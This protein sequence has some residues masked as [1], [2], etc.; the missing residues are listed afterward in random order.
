MVREEI[1]VTVPAGTF[2]QIYRSTVI[3]WYQQR[4]LPSGRQMLENVCQH[5][6]ACLSWNNIHHINGKYHIRF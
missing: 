1:S 3:A 6:E 2:A 4:E 5:C